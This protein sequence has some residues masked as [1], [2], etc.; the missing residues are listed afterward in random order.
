MCGTCAQ[1]RGFLWVAVCVLGL[2]VNQIALAWSADGD[3]PSP[4]ASLAIT[5][6]NTR[7]GTQR[8]S[9][10]CNP[11]GGSMSQPGAACT[12]LSRTL[13][14]LVSPNEG[15]VPCADSVAV[16]VVGVYAQRQ[17]DARFTS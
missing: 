2:G 13:E 16:R 12:A 17:V 14:L 10:S 9:L 1:R 3:P 8:Y 6:E 15:G 7:F 5:V 11:A 4:T